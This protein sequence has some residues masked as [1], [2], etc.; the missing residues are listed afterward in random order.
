[1]D[2]LDDLFWA[3][4]DRPTTIAQPR[5]SLPLFNKTLGDLFAAGQAKIEARK[6]LVD[7]LSAPVWQPD[8]AL[9]D[10]SGPLPPSPTPCPAPKTPAPSP[11]PISSPVPPAS[12]AQLG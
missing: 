5:P 1:M 10:R 11:P 4:P 7:L 3:D 6:F 12:P 2:F 8:P 9:S